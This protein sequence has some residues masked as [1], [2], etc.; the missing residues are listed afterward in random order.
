MEL[1]ESRDLAA[2]PSRIIRSAHR[3]ASDQGAGSDEFVS[4]AQEIGSLERWASEVAP[5]RPLVTLTSHTKSVI[6]ALIAEYEVVAGALAEEQL[7]AAQRASAAAQRSLDAV[8]EEARNVGTILER[9]ARVLTAG[10]PTGAW[11][12]EAFQGD[13]IG[14][15][16]RGQALLGA[17]T[18]RNGGGQSALAAVI[19]DAVMSTICDPAEFWKLVRAHLQLLDGVRAEVPIIASDPQFASRL[20]DVTQDLLDAARGAAVAPNSQSLRAEA[21]ELLEAGHLLVEQPL[22]FHLGAACAATTRMTFADT[23]ARDVSELINIAGARAGPSA[24]ESATLSCATH[25]RIGIS[26][27]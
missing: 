27:S 7:E 3:L 8:A 11:I 6:G 10:D 24:P 13:P 20:V 4:V 12:A 21:R 5:L 25:S 16:G 23:Q 1:L 26:R 18:G 22:K 15:I 2:L 14:A 9:A 19:Y 17:Q